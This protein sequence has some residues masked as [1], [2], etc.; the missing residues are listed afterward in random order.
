MGE[1]TES[2]MDTATASSTDAGSA[3]GGHPLGAVEE[4]INALGRRT[5]D[6]FHH[7]PFQ[8]AVFGGAVGLGA[9][10]TFGVA[11][12]AFAGLSAYVTY[13][14]FAYGES[15]TEAI[16]NTIKFEKGELAEKEIKRPVLPD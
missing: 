5:W 3:S 10:M 13:R 14:I 1:N 4:G 15:L 8:G 9:A 2:T 6:F 11:E 12:L 7:L 16:E